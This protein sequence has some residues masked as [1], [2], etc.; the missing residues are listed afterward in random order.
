MAGSGHDLIRRLGLA[1]SAAILGLGLGALGSAA[2]ATAAA[3]PGV[4]PKVPGGSTVRV[5]TDIV[6][7]QAVL[8]EFIVTAPEGDGH[9]VL[10]DC[11]SPKQAMSTLNFRTGQTVGNLAMARAGSSGGVCAY[12][13]ST[14]HVIFD[15]T[16]SGGNAVDATAPARVLDTRLAANGAAPI[17]AAGVAVVRTGR[18]NA[19]VVGNLT[20]VRASTGGFATTYPCSVARPHASA[21]NFVAG[22]VIANF[23]AVRTNAA[24]EFCVYTSS[25]A[26]LLFDLAGTAPGIVVGAP[27]R[28]LDTRAGAGTPLAGG[29]VQRLDVGVSGAKALLNLTVTGAAGAGHLTAYPCD[30]SRPNA[31]ALQ[32]T[33][34]RSQ[35]NFAVLVADAAAGICI[36][37]TTATHLIVDL[38]AL[39][40]DVAAVLPT[41]K[42]ESSKD[43]TGPSQLVTVTVASNSATSAVLSAWQRQP[44]GRFALVRGPMAGFVGEQGSGVAD[45]YSARTPLGPW[46]LSQA[47]GNLAN[48]G[49][50][51]PYFKADAWDW[52][53]GDQ[54]SPTYN[55][56]VRSPYSPGV[57]SENLYWIGQPY[58]YAVALDY[59]LERNREAGSAFFFHVSNGEPTGG[60]IS[61]GQADLKWILQWLDPS[62]RPAINTGVGPWGSLIAQRANF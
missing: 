2:P 60:C 25:V 26:H 14:A 56:H 8:G 7:G 46:T 12:T 42:L 38:T 22:E 34:G 40:A 16:A 41:R 55:T 61:V 43:W 47:F 49:T 18:P 5:L 53:N 32:F 48:P 27:E 54:N 9:A 24:G 45:A 51:L 52:W 29:A 13:T 31:S 21:V 44:D 36:Y 6:P 30:Q 58:N 23:T 37:T 3:L 17:A 39:T 59:N 10:F 11:D 4:P 33:G 57:G 19:T 15:L 20:V 50:R 62:Q 28:R 1:A 35:A